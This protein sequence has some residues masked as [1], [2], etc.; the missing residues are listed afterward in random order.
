[1]S[2]RDDF[3]SGFLLGSLIG[4]V[5]GGIIGAVVANK[6][7][8]LGSDTDKIVTDDQETELPRKRKSNRRL[9]KD[10]RLEIARQSLDD[11]ILDLDRA[12]DSVRSSLNSV[13]DKEQPNRA[14]HLSEVN[15]PD[16]E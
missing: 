4:G 9:R 6:A 8:R 7:N 12:I 16:R 11:K 14:N 2:N 1:M 15:S 13:A 5:V 3:N 10:D